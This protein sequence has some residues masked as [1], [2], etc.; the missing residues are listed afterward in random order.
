MRL[1]VSTALVLASLM[2]SSCAP[3]DRTVTVGVD[4]SPPFYVVQ[5]D[6]SVRG[7][8]VDVFSEA[9]RRRNIRIR[10]VVVDGISLD[11][12]L[13]SRLVQM[14]P[15]IAVTPEREAKLFLSEPWIESDYVLVSPRDNPVVSAAGAA[16]LRIS[17][18][19]LNGATMVAKRFLPES[20]I[21]ILPDREKAVQEMC[22]GHVDAA[23]IESRIA[24]ALLLSRPSGCG[25]IPL[26]IAYLKGASTGL[27]VA[28][29]PEAAVFA[30]EIR[31]EISAM[32]LDG[33]FEVILNKWV[34]FSA[35]AA[36]SL[37]VERASA[38][39]NRYLAVFTGGLSMTVV[40]LLLMVR[41]LKAAQ[42]RANQLREAAETA[43]D[44]AL[45]ASRA[46]SDFV[47][48]ISHE[49]RTPMN[50]VLGMIELAL[51]NGHEG[52][53]LRESL[54]TAKTSA[55]ALLMVVNDVLDFSRI[56]AGKY[57]LDPAQFDIRSHVYRVLK[58]LASQADSKGLELLSFIGFEVPERVVADANRLAQVIN[59][60]VGNA[61]KFSLHGEVELR[62]ELDRGERAHF[63]RSENNDDSARLHFTVRDTGIGIPSDRQ[64]SIFEAF[65]Q[66]DSSTTRRFGG[67]G[68]GLTIS[69]R[70]VKMMGGSLWVDSEPRR[71]STFHF[72]VNVG[73]AKQVGPAVAPLTAP[74]L[75]GMRA[76]IVDDNAAN[77]GILSEMISPWG[78]RPETISDPSLAI[79]VLTRAALDDI[80]FGLVL[81]DSIMPGMDG[82][83]LAAT[84]RA[85]PA[86]SGTAIVMLIKFGQHGPEARFRELGIV[87]SVSKPVSAIRLF[88][89]VCLVLSETGSPAGL[90]AGWAAP[91]AR[92]QTAS[93]IPLR[94]LLAED[95]A[96]NQM[97]AA[98]ILESRGHAIEIAN[99]GLEALAALERARFDVVLMDVQ[100]PLM[101][102]FEATRAIREKALA[103]GGHIPIVALTAHA[104]VGDRER[105]LAAG[106][107]GYT[108][109]P[110]RA[111]DLF[112]EI[113]RVRVLLP[114]M[115]SAAP[116][117]A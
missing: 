114:V 105:C 30:R 81:I 54:E 94:I 28:A 7:L 50:G 48:N 61:I 117:A 42:R 13:V 72:T 87:A 96:V 66:A 43:K 10:W 62:V 49:I 70:I 52:A 32:A 60:L 64:A 53:Q 9:A 76:L 21:T 33:A 74:S 115:S 77:C 78:L 86:L 100:M 51:D 71:G 103:H 55:E 22:F 15:A 26:N 116:S 5:P 110:L 38:L 67:T 34:P 3:T 92:T 12:A 88:E 106:M 109:K 57:S 46:K 93:A 6:G 102:G 65:S 17:H 56:E 75:I 99:N 83:D 113:D 111:E 63:R 2:L 58:P 69:S 25:E 39:R 91:Q 41:R 84:I 59:N 112:S 4:R 89:A 98:A 95:N 40:V 23:M 73:V 82:F 16:G 104:M 14:W 31:S 108:V 97:V 107:D 85:T 36:R 45:A 11:Q 79:G 8:G 29:V 90:T 20:K 19:R 35:E 44:Q 101:D 80:P 37:G 68:L 24:E 47:A 18:A 27:S 1:T